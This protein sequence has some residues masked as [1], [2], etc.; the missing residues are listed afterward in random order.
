MQGKAVHKAEITYC[1]SVL[2]K[3]YFVSIPQ[4]FSITLV[5]PTGSQFGNGFC[6]ILFF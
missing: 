6:V 4:S 5:H 2:K 1:K 3:A